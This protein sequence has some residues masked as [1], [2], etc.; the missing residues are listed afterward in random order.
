MNER[1]DLFGR[2]LNH[3]M[4][5]SVFFHWLT[6]ICSRTAAFILWRICLLIIPTSDLEGLISLHVGLLLKFGLWSLS[7]IKLSFVASELMRFSFLLRLFVR[8]FF[9]RLF[10]YVLYIYIKTQDSDS[11]K[12]LSVSC[13][14]IYIYIYIYICVKHKRA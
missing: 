11:C 8:L 12:N 14:Y 6:L 7:V 2:L 1:V 3:D 13:V 10:F 9:L 5:E 4:T